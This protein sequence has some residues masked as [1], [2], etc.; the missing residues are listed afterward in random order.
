MNELN[1][2]NMAEFLSLSD[3]ERDLYKAFGLKL[4]A[5]PQGMP[6][7]MIE[8]EW[9]AVKQIQDIINQPMLHYE[10]MIEIITIA[11]GQPKDKILLWKWPNSFALYNFTVEGIRQINEFEEQLSYEPSSKELSAGIDEYN[12][13]GWFTTLNRLAGGDPLKYEA[14]GKLPYH[15][16]FATLKL[17]KLDSEF[18]KR[19][20]R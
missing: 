3:K 20:L 2:Y 18:Q 14:V 16:I 9:A 11:T 17:N 4:R 1:L 12:S 6:S 7:D 13:L 8:W 5:D 15:V 10:D 19:M